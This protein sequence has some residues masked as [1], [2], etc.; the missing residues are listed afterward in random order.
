MWAPKHFKVYTERC[1]KG[2]SLPKCDYHRQRTNT[3]AVPTIPRSLE[4]ILALEFHIKGKDKLRR[5]FGS[6]RDELTAGR[7]D[8]HKEEIHE[9]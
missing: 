3:E 8:V 9:S 1:G 4:T 5:L 2:Q 7:T 6:R